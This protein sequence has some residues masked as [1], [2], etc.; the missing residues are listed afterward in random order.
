MALWTWY[1]ATVKRIEHISVHTRRFWVEL[2]GVEDFAFKAGQFITVDLPISEKRTERW[3]SYSIA[4]PPRGGNELELC[5][6]DQGGP[7]STYFFKEVEEGTD[8]RLK[9]PSGVFTLPEDL[10]EELV[11]V[12]TGTGVAP[13]R[14]M[15]W[16]LYERGY[17][18]RV[19]LIFGTRYAWDILYRK[20]F[21]VLQEDWPNF[22][23]DVVLS[24]EKDWPGRKGYVHQVYL[25]A[26]AE[27]SDKRLFFLCGW[28][29]MID[30]A[31]KLLVEELGYK[32][33]QLRVELY[34]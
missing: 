34:G 13:F 26:Y 6:S 23:Y 31:K 4:N 11:M 25:E 33:Q 16:H 19:H 5:I 30:D 18:G 1:D 2:K 32:P 12:C 15:I 24:R 17:E 9:G 29:D 10:P 3:R 22:K 14:S 7:G 28:R 21:E 27:P 8:L 20:E